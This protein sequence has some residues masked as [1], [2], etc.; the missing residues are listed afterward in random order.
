MVKWMSRVAFEF[1]GVAVADFGH[2]AA[3]GGAL[4]AGAGE[5]QRIAG[6]EVVVRGHD[7]G[8]HLGRPLFAAGQ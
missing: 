8:K 1:D 3:G 4:G 7:S 5:Q 6:Q 2:D